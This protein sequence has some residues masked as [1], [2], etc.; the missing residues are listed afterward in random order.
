MRAGRWLL[1]GATAASMAGGFVMGDLTASAIDP[2]YRQVVS[3][4][5]EMPMVGGYGPARPAPISYTPISSV[6]EWPDAAPPPPE[7]HAFDEPA[8]LPTHDYAE[9]VE[10]TRYDAELEPV[11]AM[12]PDPPPAPMVATATEERP[13]PAPT[14]PGTERPAETVAPAS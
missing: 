1:T 2:Y 6:G 10:P 4:A 9:A 7:E 11:L 5:D 12:P 14:P 8:S 3:R 13:S